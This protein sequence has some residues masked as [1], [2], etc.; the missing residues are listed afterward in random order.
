V[1]TDAHNPRAT[2]MS[3]TTRLA[4]RPDSSSPDSLGTKLAHRLGDARY[5]LWFGQTRFAWDG[6]ALTLFVP[7][8]FDKD[9]ISKCYMD[10]LRDAAEEVLGHVP[11]ISIALDS[12]APEAGLAL[13]GGGARDSAGRTLAATPFPLPQKEETMRVDPPGRPESSLSSSPRP[14][15]LGRR[16]KMLADYVVG[17]C[18]RLAYQSIVDLLQD[19]EDAPRLITLYGPPGVGK[20]HLL[21]GLFQAYLA[22]RKQQSTEGT[23]PIYLSAEEFT[24]R[25]LGALSANQMTSFRKQFRD[26]PALLIDNLQFLA[27]KKSS[28]EEFLHTLDTLLRLNR[29]VIVTCEKHPKSLTDNMPLVADRLIGGG[30]WPLD[31][32]DRLTRVNMLHAK[33]E[34]FNLTIPQDAVEFLADRMR[35]NVRELE[36]VLHTVRH[37]AQVNQQPVTLRL[38]R[39]AIAGQFPEQGKIATIPQIELHVCRYLGMETSRLHENSRARA[40]SYPR[41]LVMYLAR[42]LAG[43]SYG[44]ISRYYNTKSHTTAIA[45]ER[46]V[47]KMLEDDAPLF[48]NIDRCPVR[49]IIETVERDVYRG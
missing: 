15:R 27:G 7:T 48:A 1:S 46:K 35:G 26:V 43:A 3:T 8:Q 40:V 38:V 37:Y 47:A 42:R 19:V 23:L 12:I 20:T 6:E 49:E 45:A 17:P 44:E 25:F 14:S 10:P 24:N 21:E 18:N 39:E 30:C 13:E 34:R 5:Q 16:W 36:G 33:S 11:P 9:R 29:P 28:Q 22:L 31:L 2:D 32:P 4:L 41:M